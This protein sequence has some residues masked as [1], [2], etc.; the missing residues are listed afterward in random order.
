[1]AAWMK[2]LKQI[3]TSFLRNW[4]STWLWW[5]GLVLVIILL[6]WLGENEIALAI[7]FL[8]DRDQVEDFLEGLGIWG[9]LVYVLILMMQVFTAIIPG[10]VLMIAAGYLY[11]FWGGVALNFLAIIVASQI[12]FTFARRAGRPAV[13]R[14]VPE[15]IL[16]RW[17][18]V[19]KHGSFFFFLI[20]FWFPII[21]SSATNYIAGLS[22]I[23]GWLFLLASVLGRLPGIVL[24]TLVGSHGLELSWRQW[25]VFIPL[26]IL[27]IFGGHYLTAKLERRFQPPP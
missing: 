19:A 10:Q 24:F 20:W 2:W 8:K 14:L 26:G 11:G 13:E 18:D 12:A 4:S 6:L 7:D 23:S 21:P 17:E 3:K 22:Y 15:N 25:A 16:H 9:P 1:M 5:G 27:L